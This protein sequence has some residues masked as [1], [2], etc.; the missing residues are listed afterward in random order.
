M[1]KHTKLPTLLNLINSLDLKSADGYSKIVYK[2]ITNKENK[3]SNSFFLLNLQQIMQIFWSQTFSH[4][5]R[6]NFSDCTTLMC[7]MIVCSRDFLIEVSSTLY[8]ILSLSC[9]P[10]LL[11]MCVYILDCIWKYLFDLVVPHIRFA[12]CIYCCSKC[13]CMWLIV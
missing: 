1:E 12:L 10:L 8:K 7:N 3:K 13:S 4:N 9:I 2:R 11:C 6:Q 5:L